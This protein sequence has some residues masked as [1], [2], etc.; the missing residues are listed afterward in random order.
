M[1]SVVEKTH[2]GGFLLAEANGNLSRE[3]KVVITGQNLQAGTVL[4]IITAS[5][6]ATILAPAASDGSQN[7]AGVLYGAVDATG[8]DVPGAIIARDAEVIAAELTWPGGIS[9][10]QKV[11]ATTALAALGIILR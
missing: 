5:G 2:T 3:Q 9:G 8:A 11:T 6:K 10:P 7:A 4:G 1:T